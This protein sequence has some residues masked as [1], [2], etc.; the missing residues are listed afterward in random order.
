MTVYYSPYMDP[1]RNLALE[2][3]LFA[4]VPKGKRTLFLWQNRSSVILGRFQNAASEIDL[5]EAKERGIT[6]V[7]RLSGGGAVYHDPGNL[8][9]SLILDCDDSDS[10]SMEDFTRPAVSACRRFGAEAVFSSRNDILSDGKKLSGSAQYFRNSRL[11]HHG[12]IMVSTDLS[13]IPSVLRPKPGKRPTGAEA[14]V[15]SPVTTLS[16]A[17]GR[18]VTVESLSGALIEELGGDVVLRSLEDLCPKKEIARLQARYEDPHWTYGYPPA[19]EQTREARFD[20][21]SVRVHLRMAEGQIADVAFSGDFFC[22]GDP[23][24]LC[25]LIRGRSIDAD[26]L[27]LLEIRPEATCIRGVSPEELYRLIVG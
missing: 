25:A 10:V 9:Y 13:V 21:G 6:V 5:A 8:N 12:C 3:F 1:C 22:T 27:R 24:E 7:R 11:L 18:P 17:A 19:Y 4:V 20:G 14:S 15:V 16:L 26:L 23:E 2:E